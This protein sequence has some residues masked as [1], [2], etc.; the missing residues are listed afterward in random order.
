MTRRIASAIVRRTVEAGANRWSDDE[1]P[2]PLILGAIVAA[3]L[4]A[5]ALGSASA[6]RT[7]KITIRHQAQHCHTWSAGGAWKASLAVRLARGGTIHFTNDDVMPH[8]LVK[9][10]GPAVKL[11]GKPNMNHMSA[12]VSAKFSKP[13]VYRFTTKPGEDYMQGMKTVGEDNV[14]RLKVTV[15]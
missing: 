14:L 7:V 13:G 1:A 10:S 6:P 12:G 3:I 9:L 15:S 4:A 2:H 8:K 5:G 11:V